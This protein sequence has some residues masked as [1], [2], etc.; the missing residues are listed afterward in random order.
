MPEMFPFAPFGESGRQMSS[1]FQNL[2]PLVDQLAFVH[3]I[4][5]DINNH[6]PA[7]LQ[8]HTGSELLGSPSVG[9]WV[10]YGLGS[11]TQDL[12]GYVVICDSRAQ[13]T[14]ETGGLS[15]AY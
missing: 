8:L 3:G 7:T 6:S 4:I 10:S 9:S 2:A 11:E 12:P 13:P 1:L 15:A 5:G 14:N